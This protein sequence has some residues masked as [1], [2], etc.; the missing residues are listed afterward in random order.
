MKIGIIGLPQTGKKELFELLTHHKV[1]DK[2]VASG[3]PVKSFAEIRDPRFD[4]LVNMYKPEKEARARVDIELLPKLEKDSISKGE[5]FKDIDELDAICH[6]V[7]AF[8]DDSVY[9]M[10]GSVDP[11]RDIGF[12][13][14]ELILN[15]LM[16]I[17]KRLE[18][19]EKDVKKTNDKTAVRERELLIKLKSHLD[20]E[21]PLRLIELDL[22]EKKMLSSYP[23][24][25]LKE[26]II[27]LNVSEDDLKDST[28]VETFKTLCRPLKTEVMPVSVKIE[29]EIAGLE[30]EK[31][32]KE[33]L[34][35][36]G[37]EE[38]AIDALTRLCLKAL[39]LIS[40]FTV[41]TDEVK[42]WLV[43]RSASAPEAAGVI[44]SD[45]EKGF[46]R[47]ELIK[48]D[49]LI[50]LGSEEKV[51]EAGKFYL[52]GKDYTVEDGDILSFRFNV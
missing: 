13:N 29:S 6:I 26:M 27:V 17:E 49:D 18:R 8:K 46:I 10:S 20:K 7:R 37:I 52:K 48:Y 16:F 19:I 3:K 9:H 5:I 4:A 38:P 32:R 47:A 11:K 23:L 31:D 35:A 36:L 34:S 42:Q 14:S 33:F 44:H 40:F 15:D 41:G 39:S 28:F 2:E 50:T 25:T 12:V 51:K 1:S 30:S 22:E 24:I 21:L 43:R 45:I